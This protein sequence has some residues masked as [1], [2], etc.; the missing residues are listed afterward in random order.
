MLPRHSS[1]DAR[2][3]V[4][5]KQGLSRLMSWRSRMCWTGAGGRPKGVERDSCLA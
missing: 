4:L 1:R 5:R 3:V 2:V